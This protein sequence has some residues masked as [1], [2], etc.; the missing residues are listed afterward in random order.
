ME[1]NVLEY[2]R[3]CPEQAL[4]LRTFLACRGNLKEL[5]SKLGISYPTAKK[6]LDELLF[7]LNIVEDKQNDRKG[8]VDVTM[9]QRADKNSI[10][11]ADIIKN[12]LID[13]GGS[14]T[15]QSF[16]GKSYVIHA[17]PD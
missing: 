15:V 7:A 6:R 17:N 9:I 14:A 16:S 5:Q 8:M 10:N 11:A 12:K 2:D 13:C 3:L 1:E 4:F